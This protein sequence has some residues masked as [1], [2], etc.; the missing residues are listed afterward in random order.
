MDIF[1]GG[2]SWSVEELMQLEDLGELIELTCVLLSSTISTLCVL[3]VLFFFLLLISVRYLLLL[4]LL[5]MSQVVGGTVAVLFLFHSFFVF[6]PCFFRSFAYVIF[7]FFIF[8]CRISS[9]TFS[10]PPP[11]LSFRLCLSL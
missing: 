10:P 5:L 7:T 9:C 1:L 2:R 11:P 8:L 4:Y 6:V 3:V